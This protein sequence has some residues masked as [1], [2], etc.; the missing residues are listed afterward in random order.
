MIPEGKDVKLDC[1]QVFCSF[2]IFIQLYLPH[3]PNEDLYPAYIC[4][5]V[6]FYGRAGTN[7]TRTF[8]LLEIHKKKG[9]NPGFFLIY[10]VRNI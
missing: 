4:L 8:D 5:Y 6:Y 10:L 3:L 2:N 7:W 9:D 1:R